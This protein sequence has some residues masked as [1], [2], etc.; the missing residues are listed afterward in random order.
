MAPPRMIGVL[1]GMGPMATVDFLRK[2]IELTPAQ[3][4]QDHV[5]LIVQSIPQIPD[6]VSAILEGRNDPL[7]ALQAGATRLAD[8]G[9]ELIVMPCHT[10]HAWFVPLAASVR[11]PMLHIAT[12]ALGD[13]ERLA[14]MPR[15]IALLGTLGTLK[16][17]IYQKV[18]ASEGRQL[19]VPDDAT[20]AQVLAAIAAVK[21]NAMSEAR[22]HALEAL[23]V[24]ARAGCDAALLACTELPLAVQE[25]QSPLALLDPTTS[26]AK[27]CIAFSLAPVP[28]VLPA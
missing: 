7:P 25:D 16:A 9:A 19:I 3:R 24:L 26:L 22:R 8:A 23:G 28:V 11:V 10:A 14:V 4:D 1:G 2:I 15:R 6:R 17:G 5:P 18:L 20:Q 27:A 21:R 12:A 13:L